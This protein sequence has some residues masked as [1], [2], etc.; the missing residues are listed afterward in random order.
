MGAPLDVRE[1]RVS[2]MMDRIAR[3]A[4]PLSWW[5]CGGQVVLCTPRDARKSLNSFDRNSPA[6]SLCKV[7]MTCAG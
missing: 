2:S 3:S 7:P 5:T 6:L 1:A 4:T